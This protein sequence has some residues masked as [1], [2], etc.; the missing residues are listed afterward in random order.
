MNITFQYL[1]FKHLT[2]R[3]IL[4]FFFLYDAYS[5]YYLGAKI[6]LNVAQSTSDARNIIFT[7]QENLYGLNIAV[8]NEIELNKWF[9][10][11]LEPQ[12][13]EKGYKI[14]K[15]TSQGAL[16][17]S[18]TQNSD[19]WYL[20]TNYLEL[21]VL[22]KFYANSRI[23]SAYLAPGIYGGYWISGE[24]GGTYLMNSLG[25]RTLSP[26]ELSKKYVF[27]NDYG[28]NNKK[29]N[30]FEFGI[31]AS[32][33]IEYRIKKGKFFIDARYVYGLTDAYSYQGQK[34]NS[35]ASLYHRNWSYSIGFV[36]LLYKPKPRVRRIQDEEQDDE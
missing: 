26:V 25:S 21:P 15:Y 2:L 12:Y 4:I 10:I 19:S 5:Q 35:Y 14:R 24:K 7:K 11:R 34:P 27:D 1:N 29:D 31:L 8:V 9:A 36:M 16:E 17:Q 30:R 18:K 13:S 28:Y 20:K 3:V 32:V 22:A 23:L 6:G 33:G